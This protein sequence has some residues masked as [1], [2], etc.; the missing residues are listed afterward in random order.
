MPNPEDTVPR[1]T[2]NTRSGITWQQI[3][4]RPSWISNLTGGGT[5]TEGTDIAMSIDTA[6]GRV[7]RLVAPIDGADAANKAYVD[8]QVASANTGVA[9]WDL[10]T[11]KPLFT[12]KFEMVDDNTNV[13][14][15]TN[16]DMNSARI[17]N[18]GAPVNPQEAANK[19][20]VD[21]GI[22]VLERKIDDEVADC[23][24]DAKAY[25]DTIKSIAVA[26]DWTKV[27]NKPSYLADD[28]PIS[29]GADSVL[30]IDSN[31]SL[32][33]NTLRGLALPSRSTDAA[34]KGYVDDQVSQAA[35]PADVR[36]MIEAS[37]A[38]DRKW[39][40]ITEKPIWVG[41]MDYI[42]TPTVPNPNGLQNN[43]IHVKTNVDMDNQTIAGIGEPTHA[44]HAVPLR[45]LDTRLNELRTR[46][47]EGPA[48]GVL[49]EM[50]LDS[51]TSPTK[52]MVDLPI[53]FPA[54]SRK[55]IRNVDDVVADD[56]D[57]DYD[58]VN[59]RYVDWKTEIADYI[60][61]DST[62]GTLDVDMGIDFGTTKQRIQNVADPVELYD[63]A[64]KKHVQDNYPTKTSLLK[65]TMS[66][67]TDLALSG[68][69]EFE[70]YETWA[71]DTS[72]SFNSVLRFDT[73]LAQNLFITDI[74]MRVTVTWHDAPQGMAT[75]FNW[76]RIADIS[77]H[78][79]VIASNTYGSLWQ[80]RDKVI[81]VPLLSDSRN[82]RRYVSIKYTPVITGM[83]TTD[84]SRHIVAPDF[85]TYRLAALA[86]PAYVRY[87]YTATPQVSSPIA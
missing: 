13:K 32:A 41:K 79:M 25:A 75:S 52:I 76:Y 34:S 35:K 66:P 47:D 29:M 71:S 9:D 37:S 50:S 43:Y 67:E 2:Y 28:G 11:D 87:N 48:T 78:D 82:N 73:T 63:A 40:N 23:L 10:I 70:T 33:N 39:V 1:S 72:F 12:E 80:I 81:D 27:I 49:K 15:I 86:N 19:Q 20:Y 54:T 56:E 6:S 18:M 14:L 51:E 74:K 30:V 3:L 17:R 64:N 77:N 62:N 60:T 65:Y 42:V 4:Q 68:H 61:V 58:A 55:R 57:Y 22:D 45:Y 16:L 24:T 5:T 83:L 38:L 85:A 31:M 46:I 69:L 53:E 8:A 59:K 26:P 44:S 84:G 7:R 21:D 36:S